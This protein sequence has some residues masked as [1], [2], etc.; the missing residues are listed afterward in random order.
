[1]GGYMPYVAAGAYGAG[2]QYVSNW[3]K[4]YTSKIPLGG[5]SDE[6]GMF[7]LCYLGKKFI[8]KKTPIARQ[9]FTAGMLIESARIGEAIVNGEVLSG[10]SSQSSSQVM[11]TIY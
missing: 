2:R 5:I 4:P 1:M 3:L 6:I 9:I 7:A 11:Q 8:G 10:S